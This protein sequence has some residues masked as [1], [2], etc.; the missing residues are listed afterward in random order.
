[1]YLLRA[2]TEL[3]RWT[4]TTV[5]GLAR[6]REALDQD[7]RAAIARVPAD[8]PGP[9]GDVHGLERVKGGRHAGVMRYTLNRGAG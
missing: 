4:A 9:A 6:S 2:S 8:A 5:A 3:D 1:V 7:D